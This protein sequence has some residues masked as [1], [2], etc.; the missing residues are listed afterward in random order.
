MF[1]EGNKFHVLL[2]TILLSM[3][4]PAF[5]FA[6]TITLVG[7][8]YD[9]K[10]NE[11]IVYATVQIKNTTTGTNTDEDGRFFIQTKKCEPRIYTGFTQWFYSKY[12][13]YAKASVI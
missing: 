12:Y 13:W 7:H 8:V 6:Q 9:K 10:S 4:L 3:F 5:V 1:S 11:P 2:L